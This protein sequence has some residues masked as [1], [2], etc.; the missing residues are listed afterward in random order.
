MYLEYF[1][2]QFLTVVVLMN[3]FEHKNSLRTI[4]PQI[5]Q[6]LKNKEI[7]PKFTGSYK[8]SVYL[9]PSRRGRLSI[10]QFIVPHPKAT[11]LL[12][13]DFIVC[14]RL[15]QLVRSLTANQEVPGSIPGNFEIQLL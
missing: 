1:Q 12:Y 15:A 10:H 4:E 7:W 3:T 5:V 11:L 8:K 9:S 6:K 14:A 13:F 2:E